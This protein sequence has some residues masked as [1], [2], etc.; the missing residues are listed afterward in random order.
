MNVHSVLSLAFQN[1]PINSEPAAD[2]GTGGPAILRLLAGVWDDLKAQFTPEMAIDYG[3]NLLSAIV[4]FVLGRWLA[5]FI[6]NLIVR[7][8]KRAR[9]D[10]TLLSFV[11]NLTYMFLLTV[12]CITALGRLGVN[13]TSLSAVLAAAGFAVGMAMQGSLGNLAAGVMLVLFKPFKLGDYIMVGSTA[14]TVLEIHIFSTVLLTPDNIRIIIPNGN[15]TSDTIQNY[16]A[17]PRRRIDLLVGCGYNDDLRAVKA[18]LL[19]VVHSDSRIL[20][21]PEPVVAVSQ[22][23]DSSVNFVVRPWVASSDYWA[24]R[25]DLTEAI[26]LGFDERGFTIPFPSRDVFIHRSDTNDLTAA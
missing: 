5:R 15:I 25:F 2:N 8:A 24:T 3:L 17:E 20:Q 26:K 16:S 9:F 14:G 21:D 6:T 10:E 7:G 4:V 18:F 1:Q 13:T 11:S 22:L 19:E 23:G 12:V